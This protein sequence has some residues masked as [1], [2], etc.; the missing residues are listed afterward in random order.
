M[1]KDG[2]TYT[3]KL[4]KKC[5]ITAVNEKVL[6]TLVTDKRIKLSVSVPCA[7]VQTNNIRVTWQLIKNSTVFNKVKSSLCVA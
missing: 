3:S 6:A 2:R 5:C 7:L 1:R 4:K